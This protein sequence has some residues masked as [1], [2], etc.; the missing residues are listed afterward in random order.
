MEWEYKFFPRIL[1]WLIIII[2]EYNPIQIINLVIYYDVN[3]F[4]II[5]KIINLL[6]SLIILRAY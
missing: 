1:F 6:L 3:L 4:F 2:T 5:L